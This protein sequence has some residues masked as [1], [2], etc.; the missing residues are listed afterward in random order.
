MSRASVCPL[1]LQGLVGFCPW[2]PH[3]CIGFSSGRD[4]A[5]SGEVTASRLPKVG[6]SRLRA[7]SVREYLSRH[8]RLLWMQRLRNPP[9]RATISGVAELL[10]TSSDEL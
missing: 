2:S 5:A 7:I 3:W 9:L 4:P 1:V 10:P 6:A 8:G